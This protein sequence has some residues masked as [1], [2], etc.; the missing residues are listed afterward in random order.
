MAMANIIIQLQ[1]IESCIL[2]V[3]EIR[4]RFLKGRK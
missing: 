4:P 1:C 3:G 2:G